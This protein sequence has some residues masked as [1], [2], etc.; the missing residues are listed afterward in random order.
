MFYIC[1]M[2]DESRKSGVQAPE[3]YT[4]GVSELPHPLEGGGG[5]YPP[6]KRIDGVEYTVPAQQKTNKQFAAVELPRR[7]GGQP[8]NKNA[9]RTGRHTA[10]VK[11]FRR[12]VTAWRDR[13]RLLLAWAELVIAAR[14]RT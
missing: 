4:V 5:D 11:R 12:R 8:G 13:T 10:E 7:R 9:L 2:S 1:S 6:L 14:R 3:G